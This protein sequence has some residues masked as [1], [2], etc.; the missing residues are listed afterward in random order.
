[1]PFTYEHDSL[2][3]E[4]VPV[5]DLAQTYGTPLY[6]YSLASVRA[7]FEAIDRGFAGLEHQVCY[8]LKANSNPAIISELAKL[9]AGA[10]VV[11]GGELRLALAAGIPPEKI[12]FAGVGKT[13]AEITA[14]LETR[15]LA[16]NVESL[17]ELAVIAD[18]ARNMRVRAPVSLRVN[19]DIDIHGHPY[20]STGRSADKFGI[21]AD[22]I[23]GVMNRLRTMEAVELVGFHAHLGSQIESITPYVESARVLAGLV[24]QAREQGHS[25][26][27]V[28]VGG[29]IGVR[30]E[31]NGRL[32][33]VEPDFAVDPAKLGVHLQEVLGPLGCT[34]L[35][36]PGRALM[37]Q[38]G[39][40]LTRVTFVKKN[41]GKTFVIVDAG[42]NDLL[43]P[44]LYNAYHE[45]VPVVQESNPHEPV[46]V[47]GPVCESGD[48]LAR[49]RRLPQV[50][51]GDLLAVLTAGAYGYVLSSNYNSR[52]RPAEVLVDGA[53]HRLIRPRDEI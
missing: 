46:D 27:F 8:A 9:G 34:V 30:Y 7:S 44:S 17:Q 51:R 20:I 2:Y 33:P 31:L 43:R 11:S 37:A 29:G 3:C 10:D 21:S 22:D 14:A 5:S 50:G 4:D 24:R 15:I 49:D 45:I 40:L 26:R 42:M 23:P 6:V 25:P 39:I 16:L 53:S 48:F 18:L 35:I 32:P 19:P 28:D 12:V 52:P 41:R 38:A 36:E 47:V 1:M 13:D